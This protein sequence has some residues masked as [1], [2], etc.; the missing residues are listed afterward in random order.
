MDLE[1]QERQNINMAD[2]KGQHNIKIIQFVLCS[3]VI[4]KQIFQFP[5]G[6]GKGSVVIVQETK[7]YP[8]S[9]H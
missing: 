1:D 5:L 2:L 9:D 7:L 6:S 3:L 8:S 4:E